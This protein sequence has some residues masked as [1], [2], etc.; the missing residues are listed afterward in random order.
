MKGKKLSHNLAALRKEIDAA[1][2]QIARSLKKRFRLVAEIAKYK[3]SHGI[4]IED[5]ERDK[6]VKRSYKAEL[7]KLDIPLHAFTKSLIALMLAHSKKIQE[8]VIKNEQRKKKQ[9]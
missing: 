9:D 6:E 3:H 1:D 4:G 8:D 7:S 5:K 2:K